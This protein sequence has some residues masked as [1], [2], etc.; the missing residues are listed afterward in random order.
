MNLNNI[1][2]LSELD[3]VNNLLNYFMSRNDEGAK[4]KSKYEKM[5]KIL[6]TEKL[7]NIITFF[8][9][10]S[11]ML[12]YINFYNWHCTFHPNLIE[13]LKGLETAIVLL[14][15]CRLPHL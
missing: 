5:I 14:N 1:N 11:H 4:I 9:K 12:E 8:K 15:Y 3:S 7:E 10:N 13:M 2:Y 6:F